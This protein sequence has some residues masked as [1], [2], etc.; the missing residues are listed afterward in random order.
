LKLRYLLVSAAILAAD[1]WTK[2]LV[3]SHLPL[4]ASREILPGVLHLSH[5]RNTGVAFGLLAAEGDGL[6]TALLAAFGLAALSLIAFFFVR[7]PKEHRRLLWALALVLGGA[8]GN[9]LDR[10][11]SG[12][13]TDF[14]A[15]FIGSYRWPDFNLADSAISIGLALLVLD[16]LLPHRGAPATESA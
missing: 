13:V 3:E 12:A 2:W 14:V 7:T 1:Q 15:V 11:A 6:R 9:L 5:V 10:L 16:A 8:V 4:H